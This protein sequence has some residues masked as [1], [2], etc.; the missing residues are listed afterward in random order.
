MGFTLLMIFWENKAP[1]KKQKIVRRKRWPANFMLG[2][3]NVLVIRLLFSGAAVSAAAWAKKNNK[4][5]FNTLQLSDR[6]ERLMTLLAMDLIIYWQHRLSHSVGLLWR[7]HRVHHADLELDA[8]SGVR[9]H[10]FEAL[11]SMMLKMVSVVV[12]GARPGSVIL[13]ELV[14]NLLATFNH[15]NIYIPPIFE[16]VLRQIFITP[17][18][19]RIHH[20]VLYSEQQKNFGFSVPWW[21]KVFGSFLAKGK[22]EPDQIIL[23]D[24]KL[25]APKQTQTL[26]AT[27][28]GIPLR[29]LEEKYEHT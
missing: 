27:L 20:S 7:L 4:G 1:R 8:S 24:G 23:G 13:F 29:T 5:L 19:H 2:I 26:K 22:K 28:L 15:S 14:L 3:I 21:D 12:L 11:L 25:M 9:F 16:S 17:D 18:L 6:V 10:P